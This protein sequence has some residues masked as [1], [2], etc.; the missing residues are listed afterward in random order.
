M[1]STRPANGARRY[2]EPSSGS[3]DE[4]I[5]QDDGEEEYIE[6]RKDEGTLGDR[7]G[8]DR[9]PV[10]GG[11][12]RRSSGVGRKRVLGRPF[13]CVDEVCGKAFARKSDLVRHERI[14]SNER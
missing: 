5:K 7:E 11:S 6:G 13:A 4:R 2:V 1:V 10:V 14:H 8:H 3:E 9:K 12:A